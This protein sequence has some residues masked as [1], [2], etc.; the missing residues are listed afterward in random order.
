MFGNKY[1]DVCNTSNVNVML[2]RSVQIPR[3]IFKGKQYGEFTVKFFLY[4]PKRE[5]VS[6]QETQLFGVKLDLRKSILNN[7]LYTY[8][9]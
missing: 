4:T 7:S 3:I 1:I 9:C 8:Q 2:W 5:N 6:N